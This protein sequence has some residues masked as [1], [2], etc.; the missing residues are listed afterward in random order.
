MKE[1]IYTWDG[2]LA[3]CTITDDQGRKFIGEAVVH[4]KDMDFASEKT[5]C[6]IATI[7]ATISYLQSL[8]RDIIRPQLAA[9]NQLY[10]SMKHSTNFNPK[11]Y[12]N[13]ML[14]RQIRLKKDDLDTI[15]EEIAKQR[16]FLIGYLR[17]K[18]EFYQAVRKM[19]EKTASDE[20]N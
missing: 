12:E 15:N 10:Y 5:G 16:Y 17:E 2:V 14:Q 7:R 11:S 4:E 9:L 13:I 19:R 6:T 20:I 8:K 1:P 18:E 3:T